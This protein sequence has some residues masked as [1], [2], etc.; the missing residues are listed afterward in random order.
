M[1]GSRAVGFHDCFREAR[2]RP[3][4]LDGH[5]IKPDPTEDTI[6]RGAK[7]KT[8]VCLFLSPGEGVLGWVVFDA[9]AISSL[10]SRLDSTEAIIEA[11]R[12]WPV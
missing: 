8:I 4:Q 5:W 10:R 3:Q 9:L 2:L 1:S 12:T 6:Y 11:G 7:N